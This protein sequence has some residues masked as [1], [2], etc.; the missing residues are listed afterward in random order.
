MGTMTREL[1][2]EISEE[3]EMSGRQVMEMGFII[4]VVTTVLLWEQEDVFLIIALIVW[5]IR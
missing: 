3:G 1:D 4:V 2:F 5:I